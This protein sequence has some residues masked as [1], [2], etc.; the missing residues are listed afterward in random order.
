M[1]KSVV[2]HHVCE[3]LFDFLLANDVGKLHVCKVNKNAGLLNQRLVLK[4]S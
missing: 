1:A 4:L 2:L 3:L